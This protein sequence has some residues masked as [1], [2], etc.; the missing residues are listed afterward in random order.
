MP[1]DKP[2]ISSTYAGPRSLLRLLG[3][4]LMVIGGIFTIIAMIDFFTSFGTF[5]APSKFW[6]AFVG[7]PLI[8]VGTW[9]ARF[10]YLGVA[11]GYVAGEVAPIAKDVANYLADETE[12]A[13]ATV[14]RAITR[15]VTE[16]VGRETTRKTCPHCRADNDPDADYCASCGKGLTKTKPCPACGHLS[17]PDAHFCDECGK[18]FE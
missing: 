15:G 13:T 8:G 18:G 12:E 10:G 16:G 2:D 6:M 1:E 7:L 9:M 4:V 17:Y 14:A 11:A 3:P 5:N